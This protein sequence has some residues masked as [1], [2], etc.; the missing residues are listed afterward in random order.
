MV[1]WRERDKGV[2]GKDIVEQDVARQ[3]DPEVAICHTR[4][5]D[6]EAERDNDLGVGEVGRAKVGVVLQGVYIPLSREGGHVG[7]EPGT[8]GGSEQGICT[9]MIPR[10]STGVRE[11]GPGNK[12]Y[13]KE[14][15][16]TNG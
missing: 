1:G 3:G 10:G 7:G 12:L 13:R 8:G 16:L 14:W 9:E 6:L 2:E 15:Y 5:G 4:R 11:P